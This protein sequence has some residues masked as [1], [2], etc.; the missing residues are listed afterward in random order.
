MQRAGAPVGALRFARFAQFADDQEKLLS[1]PLVGPGEGPHC[2]VKARIAW[3]AWR[4]EILTVPLFASRTA[5]SRLLPSF[6][7][8]GA[9][10]RLCVGP[11]TWDSGTAAEGGRATGKERQKD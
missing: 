8:I 5:L 9:L 3:L 6:Y 7:C 2:R 4:S 10:P 11:G 1:F